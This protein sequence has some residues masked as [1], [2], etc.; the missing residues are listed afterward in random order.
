MAMKTE[1]P[2]GGGKGLKIT[3]AVVMLGLGTVGILYGT[4]VINLG[5]A[6]IKDPIPPDQKAA[7]SQISEQE[8]KELEELNRRAVPSSVN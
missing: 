7:A 5:P 3:L 8:K 1:E 6:P 4:G 2:S